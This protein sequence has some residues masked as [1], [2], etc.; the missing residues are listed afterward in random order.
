MPKFAAN[1]SMMFTE[2]DFLDR[3]DMAAKAGFKGVE[4]L[5]PY[6]HPAPEIKERLDG[7]GLI[8]VLFNTPAGDWDA[9]DRGIAAVP[10]REAEFRDGVAL[11]AEYAGA[12]GG[13]TS[14]RAWWRTG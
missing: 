8:Q 3:F 9:G 14:C 1:L 7:L 13:S 10:G 11:A 12:L 2:V 5:F 4:F 6:A